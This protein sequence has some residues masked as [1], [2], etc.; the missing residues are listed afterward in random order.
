VY[1]CAALRSKLR[2]YGGSMPRRPPNRWHP[3]TW[4][5]PRAVASALAVLALLATV[6]LLVQAASGALRAPVNL[7]PPVIFGQAQVGKTL[8]ASHG[9]WSGKPTSFAYRWLRCPPP[10]STCTGIGHERTYLVR[11]AD[12]GSVI[13]VKVTARDAAGRSSATSTPTAVVISGA[14]MNISVPVISGLAQQGLTLT[15]S[16]GTWS[17]SPTSYAYHWLRCDPQGAECASIAG[18]G[19]GHLLALADVGSRLRVRVTAESIAGR[20]S[21]TS[22]PSELVAGLGTGGPAHVM[23][24]V[25]E[26]RNRGEVIGASNMPYFNSLATR[27]GNTTAWDGVSHPS[28]PNYLALISGSTQGVS[29]DECGHS[30]PGVPTIGSELSLAGISWKAYLEGLPAPGSE[31]CTSGEYDKKHNPFAYFPATNGTNVVP[32][33]QF[34]KDLSAGTL[35]AFVFYVPN[36]I[37]DGHDAGNEVVDKYLNGLIPGVLASSWY[38]EEGTV[39][40]T[41]DEDQGEGKVATV[42]LHGTG[43]GKVLTAA[44]N[45]YGTLATIEDLYGVPRLGKAVSATTLAPLLK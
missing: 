16:R 34:A 26:N 29:D 44:G 22:E 18:S 32:A 5:G 37:N 11:K 4:L 6:A 35:P 1:E 3:A 43:S 7:K 14:P 27:Y 15:A 17:G 24:I 2:E 8:T 42:V 45:H 41:W 28:L 10:G 31:A 33:S 12:I 21:A 36:L 38:A 9:S 25:E 30:F 23:V 40:I 19:A 20:S 39:I 13:R